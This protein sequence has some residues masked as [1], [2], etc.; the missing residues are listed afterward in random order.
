MLQ[1]RRIAWNGATE[2]SVSKTTNK[3]VVMRPICYGRTKTQMQ[4]IPLRQ[5]RSTHN[6]FIV[7]KM[8]QQKTALKWK[9]AQ[10]RC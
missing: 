2:I 3:N 9:Q 8:F 10:N 6:R 1:Q 4:V 5:I 7:L